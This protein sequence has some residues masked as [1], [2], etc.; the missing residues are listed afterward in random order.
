MVIIQSAG[1]SIL[2]DAIVGFEFNFKGTGTATRRP[3]I[4]HIIKDANFEQ[5]MCTLKGKDE[6][7]R[8]FNEQVN[9]ED[10]SSLIQRRK[11]IT[12]SDK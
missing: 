2:V 1:K 5:P 3:L 8:E 4:V 7:G 10:L 12:I 9:A 6:S 11:T